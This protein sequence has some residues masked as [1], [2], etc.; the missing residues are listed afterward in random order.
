MNARSTAL[1]VDCTAVGLILFFLGA[2]TGFRLLGQF[3]I[4]LMLPQCLLGFALLTSERYWP[5]Y[6]VVYLIQ[7]I[8][9]TM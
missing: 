9:S 5:A 1:L 4:F 3:W 6:K 2:E 7:T 8:V